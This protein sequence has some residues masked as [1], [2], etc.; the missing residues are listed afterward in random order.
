MLDLD[1]NVFT[2]QVECVIAEFQVDT[3]FDMVVW[4]TPLVM[5]LTKLLEITC[6][7]IL[8]VIYSISLVNKA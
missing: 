1:N 8:S 3:V 6:L 7:S 2:C 4:M 5:N